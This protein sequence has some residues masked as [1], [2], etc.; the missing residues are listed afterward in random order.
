MISLF[1][2]PSGPPLDFS[3]T[4]DV[5][6][7]MFS[8]SPPDLVLQNGV[9]TSYTLSCT[10]TAFSMQ[11]T[12]SVSTSQ[13]QYTIDLFTPGLSF[14]CS[15]YATNAIDDGPPTAS[16]FVTTESKQMK[17]DT[18]INVYVKL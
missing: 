17:S 8:W 6:A 3:V 11:Q 15:V 10:Y 18:A 7:M 16:V 13:F 5:T 12:T 4:V 9:I 2:A 14:G 1:I